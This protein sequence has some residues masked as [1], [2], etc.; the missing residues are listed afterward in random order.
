MLKLPS[1]R[2][3]KILHSLW[4]EWLYRGEM[5]GFLTLKELLNR[6]ALHEKQAAYSLNDLV[7]R[8]FIRT[9]GPEEA[10]EFRITPAGRELAQALEAIIRLLGSGRHRKEVFYAEPISGEDAS[11]KVR[12]SAS[13]HDPSET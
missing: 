4:E 10:A 2:K 9:T 5:D 13:P 3:Q 11:Q 7:A 8:N 6:T 12:L 1:E